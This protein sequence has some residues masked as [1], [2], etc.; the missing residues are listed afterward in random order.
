VSASGSA[1]VTVISALTAAYPFTETGRDR[2]PEMDP[3]HVL[4]SGRDHGRTS[5]SD[6]ETS[7][8]GPLSGSPY[9]ACF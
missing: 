2:R 1:T 7:Q 6:R 5:G 9:P 4:L 3:H 8:S